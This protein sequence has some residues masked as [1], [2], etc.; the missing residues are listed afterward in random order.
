MAV[1]ARVDEA[2]GAVDEQPQAAQRALALQ[3]GDEVRTQRDP[4][5]GRAEHELA[6]MENEGAV[7]VDLDELSQVLLGALRVDVGSG[8][9]AEDAE[10]AVHT[11]VHRR[12]LE[13]TFA[14][15]LDRYSALLDFFPDRLVG[16]D[17]GP[18]E[19][20]GAGP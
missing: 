11:H 20:S 15:R 6:W 3:P 19:P 14:E 16:E 13:R 4:L 2:G 18:A 1:P 9:V 5:E 12:R 7:V 8:V 10:V 17:H